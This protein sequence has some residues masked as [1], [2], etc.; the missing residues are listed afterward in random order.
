MSVAHT[1]LMA[2]YHQIKENY[3]DALLFFQVGDFYELFFDD[4]VQAARFL[5]ITLTKRGKSNGVDIPLC[6][7]PVHALHFYLTKLVKGGFSVALCDQ[8]S[9]P[10]PGTVVERAVT[11]VYTPGTL[12]D[13]AM[14]NEK[15]ASYLC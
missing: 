2:Q 5:A 11:K 13:A 14:L 10:Q 4:A 3:P 9:K 6:G 12:T 8:R 1:P 15:K 7:V